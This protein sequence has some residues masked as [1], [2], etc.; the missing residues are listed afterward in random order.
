[1][2]MI[3]GVARTH[4][5]ASR[6]RQTHEHTHTYT[7]KALSAVSHINRR[8]PPDT[9]TDVCLFSLRGR[10]KRCQHDPGSWLWRG[11]G[12]QSKNLS[13][14][15][16]LL[17]CFHTHTVAAVCVVCFLRAGP[18]LARAPFNIHL[19]LCH[20]MHR[21]FLFDCVKT[22]HGCKGNE[23]DVVFWQCGIVMCSDWDC[24]N[25]SADRATM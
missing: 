15:V 9:S 5:Q 11:S 10:R 22:C 1:M 24:L 25:C 2:V 6:H 20:I 21:W 8:V 13:V 23:C 14:P 4:K 3:E 7:H 19:S 17:L 12:G 16:A 18:P